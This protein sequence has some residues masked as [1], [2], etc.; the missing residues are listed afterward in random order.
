MLNRRIIYIFLSI[1]FVI[2]S[3]ASFVMLPTPHIHRQMDTLGVSLRYYQKF[4]IEE[5]QLIKLLPSVLQASDG[6]GIAAMEFPFINI[7][8]SPFFA[9][10]ANYKIEI[11]YIAY[12]LIT[13][14]IYWI[15]IKSWKGIKVY[16]IDMELVMVLT[17][18]LSIMP[19][20]FYKVV[21]DVW[22]FY[23]V[24]IGIGLSW[25][26]QKKIIAV[27]LVSLGLLIKPIT[28]CTYAIYLMR[29]LKEL[30]K[31]VFMFIPV[32]I[33]LL[34]YTKGIAFINQYSDIDTFSI[35]VKSVSQNFL[36][37]K[38][39]W[40]GLLKSLNDMIIIRFGIIL[41][42]ILFFS[43]LKKDELTIRVFLI[44]LLQVSFIWMVAGTAMVRHKYYIISCVPIVTLLFVHLI[45]NSNKYFIYIFIL[46]VIV[47]NLEVSISESKPIYSNK[48][49]MW[50]ISQDCKKIRKEL[51]SL[52]I[53]RIR[54]NRE[55]YP[56]LGLC[57]YRISNSVESEYGVYYNEAEIPEE[58]RII[59]KYKELSLSKCSSNI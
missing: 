58:C 20:H 56:M 40:P 14:L 26:N 12:C 15:S 49:Q 30:H 25:N 48:K 27:T 33:A 23:I 57:S 46:L 45:K 38:E 32:V 36:Y 41:A 1:K 18:V 5:F 53:T 51:D 34:Y 22:S 28:A 8:L 9:L 10:S 59:N 31:K 42:L 47:R 52:K 21:P 29:D 43:K 54:T 4:F 39:Y 50:R 44:L 35:G 13:L 3:I 16:S 17:P 55:I 19:M 2:V 24:M 6:S 7:L 11:V 37:I